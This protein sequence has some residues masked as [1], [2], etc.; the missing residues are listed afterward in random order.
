[1]HGKTIC[2]FYSLNILQKV[3]DSIS[4]ILSGQIKAADEIMKVNYRSGC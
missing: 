1:M 2:G 4:G 3:W